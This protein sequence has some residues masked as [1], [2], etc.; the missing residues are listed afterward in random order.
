MTRITHTDSRLYCTLRQDASGRFSE[1]D[2]SIINAALACIPGKMAKVLTDCPVAFDRPEGFNAH[3]RH[4]MRYG[5]TLLVKQHTL[6]TDFL[7]EWFTA[8]HFAVLA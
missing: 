6:T 4:V 3:L 8:S 1:G 7:G 5:G 2:G